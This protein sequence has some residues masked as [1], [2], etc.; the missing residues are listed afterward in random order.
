MKMYYLN[1]S[2]Q[3]KKHR[4]NRK[5]VKNLLKVKV[6]VDQINQKPIKAKVNKVN[7]Y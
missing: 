2:F 4:N 1:V 7:D 5:E 3:K 6:V